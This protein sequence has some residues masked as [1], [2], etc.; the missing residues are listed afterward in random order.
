MGEGVV[1]N[2]QVCFGTSSS[3]PCASSVTVSVVQCDSFVA[4][5]FDPQSF[6]QGS[7]SAPA[8]VCTTDVPP[9][10]T[11]TAEQDPDFSAWRKNFGQSMKAQ[12][13]PG[14]YANF[15]AAAALANK[16]N[17]NAGGTARFTSSNRFAALSDAEKAKI[18][19][20]SSVAILDV[21]TAEDLAEAE[22]DAAA[23][24]AAS[25]ATRRVLLGEEKGIGG[26]WGGEGGIRAPRAAAAAGGQRHLSAA[27]PASVDLR[28]WTSPV[29]DQ[30]RG[31]AFS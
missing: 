30:V 31:G 1:D 23:A 6:D 15:K 16:L 20:P 5:Q 28:Q 2:Q 11:A 22:A 21:L 14:R 24:A 10:V 18:T 4:F 27:T 26:A 17:S 8:R 12:D 7:S 9:N 29:Q 3:D 13:I 19:P 25:G